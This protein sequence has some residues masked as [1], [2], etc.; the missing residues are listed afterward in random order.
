[1]MELRRRNLYNADIGKK[2][3][4]NGRKVMS[5][6][7]GSLGGYHKTPRRLVMSCAPPPH[8]NNNERCG[9]LQLE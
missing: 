5:D 7:Q 3:E 2:I 4:N 1:M 8:N 6:L 9:F